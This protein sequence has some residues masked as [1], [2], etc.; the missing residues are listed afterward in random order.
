MKF[1][2]HQIAQPGQ[3]A[4]ND[5]SPVDEGGFQGFGGDQQHPRRLVHHLP[6]RRR[7]HVAMPAVHGHANP[8]TEVFEA[9]VLVV[10][11]RLQRRDVQHLHADS[12]RIHSSLVSCANTRS[13]RSVPL[14]DARQVRQDRQE[15]GLGLS[16]GGRR[17]D[18][19]IAVAVEYGDGGAFLSVVQRGPALVV[20]PALYTR[21][22][23]GECRGF[24]RFRD[25]SG[26]GCHQR[27]PPSEAMARSPGRS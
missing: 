1:V 25:G 14:A 7:R 24:C 20:D 10:D 26:R 9:P 23:P 18:D 8:L 2:D 6:L 13:D 16:G 12:H 3:Q 5:R 17:D 22:Q 15:G 11:Q 4:R 19:H 27:H 21:I